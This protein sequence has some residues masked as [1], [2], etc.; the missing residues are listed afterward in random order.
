[1]TPPLIIHDMPEDVRFLKD[2]QEYAFRAGFNDAKAGR[3]DGWANHS[4]SYR[5]GQEATREIL[6]RGK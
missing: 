1:M 6:G 2:A 4:P 5:K 3:V